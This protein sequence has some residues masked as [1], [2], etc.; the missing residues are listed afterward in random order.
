MPPVLHRSDLRKLNRMTSDT[1]NTLAQLASRQGLENREGPPGAQGPPGPSNFFE[2]S[3]SSASATWTV[4][5]DLGI[6][7]AVTCID[8]AGDVIEG[9]IEYVSVNELKIRFSAA[10]SGTAYC[11]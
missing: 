6:F 5:H 1:S 4:T 3:Q 11:N 10:V 8:T 7:P 2:H 9:Q